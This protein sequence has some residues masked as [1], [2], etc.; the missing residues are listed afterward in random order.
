MDQ[1]YRSK[2]SRVRTPRPPY[3]VLEQDTLSS[4][5]T[6]KYPGSGGSFKKMIEKSLKQREADCNSFIHFNSVSN[7]FMVLNLTVE[8]SS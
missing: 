1:W 2:R 4:Q 5:S 8:F 7:L 6:G 3:S